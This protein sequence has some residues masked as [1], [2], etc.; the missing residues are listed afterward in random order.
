MSTA[1]KNKVTSIVKAV[2]EIAIRSN[3]PMSIDEIR[4][5][6]QVEPPFQVKHV[7]GYT[8]TVEGSKSGGVSTCICGTK[9]T[10]NDPAYIVTRLDHTNCPDVKCDVCGK[11]FA[12]PKIKQWVLI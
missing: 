4:A 7:S 11:S 10:A 2:R 6:F 1:T 5:K 8:S 3:E 9:Y 12:D